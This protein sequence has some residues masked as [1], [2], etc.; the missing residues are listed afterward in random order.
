MAR[1]VPGAFP[2]C[3]FIC[4]INRRTGK[5]VIFIP[6]I[7]EGRFQLTGC[8]LKGKDMSFFHPCAT[9]SVKTGCRQAENISLLCFYGT[10]EYHISIPIL[11][12]A[13]RIVI[14]IAVF[15][16]GIGVFNRLGIID[17]V[18]YI[19]I[20]PFIIPCF[21][22]AAAIDIASVRQNRQIGCIVCR[23][24]GKLFIFLSRPVE[25]AETIGFSFFIPH[26]EG[27]FFIGF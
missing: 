19:S 20:I 17:I 4:L 13:K 24:P 23:F 16:M 22:T 11:Y 5:A 18:L 26:T 21:F 15:R 1:V 2:I 12:I 8:I 10:A 7:A 9:V 27:P 6:R 25:T 3:F 14:L